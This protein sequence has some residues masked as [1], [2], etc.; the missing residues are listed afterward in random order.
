MEFLAF[1]FYLIKQRNCTLQKI[2][3]WGV[4]YEM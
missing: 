4:T 1:I 3:N 2:D